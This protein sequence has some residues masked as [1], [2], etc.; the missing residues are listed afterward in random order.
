MNSNTS[1][2]VDTKKIPAKYADIFDMPAHKSNVHPQM[3][4]ENRAAQFAPFAALVGYD[5]AV[6]E[7]AIEA[8]NKVIAENTNEEYIP[9]P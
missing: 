3:S 5:D 9:D 2:S 7:A 1:Q 4:I 8:F 6:E